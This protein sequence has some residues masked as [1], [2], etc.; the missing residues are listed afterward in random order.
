M[1]ACEERLKRLALLVTALILCAAGFAA[2]GAAAHTANPPAA[3][4]TAT[5][6]T[7][8][9]TSTAPPPAN[10]GRDDAQSLGALP[11]GASGT[12]VGSTLEPAEPSSD[13][14]RL[15]GSVWYSVSFGASAPAEAGISLNAGGQL[16]ACV[17]V[18][19]KQRSENIPVTGAQTDKN[20]LAR[21]TFTPQSRSTYLIRIGQLADSDPATFALDVFTVAPSAAA[22]G[23]PLPA[24]GARGKLDSFFTTTA[25]YSTQLTAAVT[26]KLN[27]I[28]RAGGCMHVSVYGPGTTDFSSADPVLRGCG[29]YRLFTPT[30]TGLYSFLVGAAAGLDVE[31]PYALHVE[32]ASSQEMAPGMPLDN[33]TSVH[34]RLRGNV[35]DVIRLY[36]LNVTST[37]QLTLNLSAPGFADFDLEL[38]NSKGREIQCE[39]GDSGSQTLQ[40]ITR[41][42]MYYAAVQAD[43]F[44]FGKFSLSRQSRTITRLKVALNGRGASQASAGHA[45][46]VSA[47]ISPAV[48][49]EVTFE[50]EYFDPLSGWQF[51]GDFTEP[52][53][54]GRAAFSFAPPEPGRWRATAS[55]GGTRSAAP[56]PS[57]WAQVNQ[58]PAPA[59]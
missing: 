21:L 29:G 47:A 23:S 16:D 34:G 37:S 13:C 12:T 1:E 31:Q 14:G 6:K 20:G 46:Q 58:A 9:T 42:G 32:A 24:G 54:A 27:L 55:F 48:Q 38:L 52:L 43:D 7:T 3:A 57:G 56:A 36:R 30:Q 40:A 11:A 53:N 33:L 51:R 50:L 17:D 22:P 4:T 44:S 41:P 8:T 28:D 45:F 5:T 59:N 2:T 39:C 18:F 15:A 19:M 49:G 25:A 26:Y 35:D 10:D